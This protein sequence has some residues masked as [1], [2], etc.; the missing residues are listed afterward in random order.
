MA[1]LAS[2]IDY[3]LLRPGTRTEEISHLCSEALAWRFAAVCVPPC[4][5]SLARMWLNGSGVRVCSVVGFPHGMS[6]AK[7][8][9]IEAELLI[10]QQVEEL[11]LVLNPSWVKNQDW[12]ALTDEAFLFC[13]LC[14]S[15]GALSKLIIESGSLS[16]EEIEQVCDI[17][18]EVGADFVKTSTGFSAVGAELEKVAYMR[19]IL[20]PET[21]IKASGGIRDRETAWAFIEAGAERIGTSALLY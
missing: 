8:K 3:T 12:E 4:Y 21:R 15:H 2:Y 7:A 11:D 5:V 17:C 6:L 16:L 19:Q 18:V 13:K 10:E 14:K 9:L 20:P 1:S